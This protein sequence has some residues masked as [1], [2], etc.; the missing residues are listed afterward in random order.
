LQAPPLLREHRLYQADWLTRFYGFSHD[1]I[2]PADTG[3]LALDVDPKLAWALAHG[4][5]FP[6][7]LNRA[8]REML[9]RVPGLGVK[10]VDKILASRRARRLRSSDLAQLRVP[11]KKLLPFV[12]VADHCPSRDVD[13]PAR[14]AALR[15][16]VREGRVPRL[17]QAHAHSQPQAQGDLFAAP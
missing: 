15:P 9:L 5:L 7:D 16:A 14:A 3:M 13:S 8:P 12:E 6:V 2:L 4:E 10:A 1:E 17:A 11:L